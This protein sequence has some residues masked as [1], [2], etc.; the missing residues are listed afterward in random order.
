MNSLTRMTLLALM[1]FFGKLHSEEPHDISLTVYNGGYAMIRETRD[2]TLTKGDQ[3][4][5]IQGVPSQIE[6]TSVSLQT[7]GQEGIVKVL[8]QNYLYDLVNRRKLMQRYIDQDIFL[9]NGKE[10]HKVTLLSNEGGL[11]VKN[12]E[13]I[14]LS[15]KGD[16][17]LPRLSEG[18]LTRPTLKWRVLSKKEGNIPLQLSY[19]STGLSWK[20]DYN[21]VINDRG[22]LADISSWISLKNYSG[23]TFKNAKIKLIA[24]DVHR[25]RPQVAVRSHARGKAESLGFA[26]NSAV[27]EKTFGEYHLYEMPYR[28]DLFD[29][30][31]KQV[32]FINQK[33]VVTKK[34]YSYQVV[35]NNKNVNVQLSFKNNEKSGM[36]L[37][38]PAGRVRMF[39]RDEDDGQLEFIG[40]DRI[41]HTARDEEVSLNVGNAFDLVGECKI[42]KIKNSGLVMKNRTETWKVTV[43]NRKEKDAVVIRVKIPLSTGDYHLLEKNFEFKKTHARMIETEVPLKAGEVKVLKYRILYNW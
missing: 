41:R 40:E 25:Y 7:P 29:Q 15:P 6:A 20:A 13:E 35:V 1:C 43:K 39:Q 37:P 5:K 16:L 28:S 14:H 17:I 10:R 12:G 26:G 22:D 2:M 11:I 23:A 3:W 38:L 4:L 27:S 21:L 33:A 30:Q 34:I 32:E 42:L 9:A 19:L 24:G 36:G 18:L 8:E 31:L